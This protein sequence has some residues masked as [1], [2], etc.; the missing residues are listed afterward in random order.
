LV[1]TNSVNLRLLR[2]FQSPLNEVGEKTRKVVKMEDDE[3]KTNENE[4]SNNNSV[5]CVRFAPSNL[6][7]LAVG[8]SNG[9]LTVFDYERGQIRYRCEAGERESRGGF[10]TRGKFK[11]II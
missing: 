10:L 6:P 7:W 9:L 11:I 1:S 3:Q 8:T 4:E 2:T 5:E